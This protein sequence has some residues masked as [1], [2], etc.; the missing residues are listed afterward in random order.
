MFQNIDI[1]KELIKVRSVSENN[2]L[3][4][5]NKQ[6]KDDFILEASI[7]KNLSNYNSKNY[8][9]EI[10]SKKN[11][12]IFNL[13]SIKNIATQWWVFKPRYIIH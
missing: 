5:V 7:Q 3:N 10:N 11:Y 2:L 13:K 1:E 6:L 4:S 12:S 8:F 9:A